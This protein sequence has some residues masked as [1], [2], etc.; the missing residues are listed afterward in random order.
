LVLKTYNFIG[1][2]VE[3][4]ELVLDNLFNRWMEQVKNGSHSVR[5]G[6]M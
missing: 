4:M 5:K 1:Y 3:F 2:A 6:I